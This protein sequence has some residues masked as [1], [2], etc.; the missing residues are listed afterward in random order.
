MERGGEE[1]SRV[2][3]NKGVRTKGKREE[4]DDC[5]GCVNKMLDAVICSDEEAT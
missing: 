4:I 3:Y 5:K 2:V 1:G